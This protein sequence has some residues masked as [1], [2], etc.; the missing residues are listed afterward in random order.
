MRGDVR[1]RDTRR[2][3]RLR[4]DQR[5]SAVPTLA[6]SRVE[7]DL[8]EDGYLGPEC[9]RELLGDE[10]APAHTEE[11]HRLP[12]VRTRKGTHVLDDTENLL[13][14]LLG[15]GSCPYRHIR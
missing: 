5:V 8:A 2:S 10:V 4:N 9:R 13:V 3:L 6:E 14:S 1:Q 12:A 11:I 7:G 15:E